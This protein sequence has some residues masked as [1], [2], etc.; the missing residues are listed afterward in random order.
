MTSATKPLTKG[1]IIILNHLAVH[2]GAG[3]MVK[4]RYRADAAK[5][6]RALLVEAW[7]RQSPMSGSEGPFYGLTERGQR[8][9]AKLFMDRKGVPP[10]LASRATA[11]QVRLQPARRT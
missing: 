2:C 4:L 7:Y 1:E 5:L 11:A 6:W 9:A 10:R 3:G 8:L